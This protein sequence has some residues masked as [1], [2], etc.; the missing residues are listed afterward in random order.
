MLVLL[1]LAAMVAVPTC[2][3]AYILNG[4]SIIIELNAKVNFCMSFQSLEL[5]LAKL[6]IIGKS[7]PAYGIN[8]I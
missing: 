5:R 4:K 1:Q 6:V 2:M 8:L 7:H 3:S